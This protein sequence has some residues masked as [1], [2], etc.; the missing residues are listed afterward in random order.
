MQVPSH[1]LARIVPYCLIHVCN[2]VHV[3][4]IVEGTCTCITISVETLNLHTDT[5]SILLYTK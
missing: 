5:P 2:M 4:V 3:P 1:H